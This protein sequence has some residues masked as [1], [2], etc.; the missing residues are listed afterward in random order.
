MSRFTGQ[1]LKRGDSKSWSSWNGIGYGVAAAAS[2]WIDSAVFAEENLR[3]GC[4]FR[5]KEPGFLN[6]THD[7]YPGIP[8][9]Q[10]LLTW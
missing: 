6:E 2:W 3:P 1:V 7:S 9:R 5:V 10:R 8:W 4:V